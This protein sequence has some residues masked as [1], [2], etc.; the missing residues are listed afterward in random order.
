MIKK[1]AGAICSS[2]HQP[3]PEPQGLNRKE[4]SEKRNSARTVGAVNV[5]CSA[6]A[7]PEFGLLR[8]SDESFTILWYEFEPNPLCDRI[9]PECDETYP[10]VPKLAQYA[11]SFAPL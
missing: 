7:H 9:A 8:G 3:N 6:L 5:K 10:R 1:G 11:C 2:L 4:R